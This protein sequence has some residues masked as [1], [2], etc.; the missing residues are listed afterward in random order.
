[1][2]TSST[3][4]SLLVFQGKELFWWCQKEIICFGDPLVSSEGK[5]D[6][7]KV[8]ANWIAHD[9]RCDEEG[10]VECLFWRSKHRSRHIDN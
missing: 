5:V 8:G 3:A 7:V 6:N 1:M 9:V 2:A 10:E 4:K